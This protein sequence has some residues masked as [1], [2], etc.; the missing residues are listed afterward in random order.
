MLRVT[1][2]VTGVTE[3]VWSSQTAGRVV[4]GVVRVTVMLRM[5]AHVRLRIHQVVMGVVRVMRMVV[6]MRLQR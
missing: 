4:V 5:D 1:E 2:R 3:L 6:V